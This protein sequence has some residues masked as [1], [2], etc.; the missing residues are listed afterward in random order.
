[1]DLL[2]DNPTVVIA[3]DT[4]FWRAANGTNARVAALYQWLRDA[5][6]RVPVYLLMKPQDGD[7]RMLDTLYPDLELYLAPDK[8]G[9]IPRWAKRTRDGRYI[10][11]GYEPGS[12]GLP[13]RALQKVLP[14]NTLK[15]LGSLKGKL[16]PGKRTPANPGAEPTLDSFRNDA[17]LAHFTTLC[18]RLKPA[19]VIAQYIRLAYLR[20]AT[21][22]PF[23]IDTIDIMHQRAKAFHDHGEQHW[24][25]ISKE[26]E[27]ATL[28]K[29]NAVIA[30]QPHEAEQLRALLP[31]TPVLT[32]THPS[33]IYPHKRKPTDHVTLCYVGGN[34]AP[35]VQ[36]LRS[37]LD[38]I[39]PRLRD[40]YHERI[41]LHIAG[42]VIAAF[43]EEGPDGVVWMGHVDD[44]AAFYRKA[45]I[46]LNPVQFGGG[47]KIKCVEALCHGLPLVTTPTGAE[48][49][50]H[51]ANE[52]FLMAEDDNDFL[53]TLTTLIEEPEHRREQGKKALA[54]AREN[55][56]S[57]A[58]FGELG[59]YLK[60]L[61]G[62]IPSPG[63][64]E[65][66]PK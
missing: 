54:F 23:I 36:A 28:A 12:V 15:S 61:P 19:A 24:I 49:L 65:A 4:P 46:A 57:Q 56:S 44:L 43:P 66:P 31:K 32:A 33:P 37:F 51:G 18:K 39:W 40:Q 21:R 53:N 62:G 5:G 10:D 52:A 63:A 35:N 20:E 13:R 34:S 26:E 47:L 8:S 16:K 41:T 29:C 9:K 11:Q 55:F 2:S 45:D 7:W 42:G 22:T 6:Y 3:T 27:V 38:N 30:I 14:E 58:A 50:E 59:A 1:M 64:G 17:A 25:A 48:G 60:A